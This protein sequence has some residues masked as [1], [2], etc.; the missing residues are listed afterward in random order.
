[1]KHNAGYQHF[2]IFF[3][4]MFAKAFNIRVNKSQDHLEKV[5]IACDVGWLVA[6]GV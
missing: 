4:M 5:E 6:F 1:M 2:L 3:L